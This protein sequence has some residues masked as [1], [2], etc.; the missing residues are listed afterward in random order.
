MKRI[1]KQT[2]ETATVVH[3]STGNLMNKRRVCPTALTCTK[4]IGQAPPREVHFR[5]KVKKM[6]FCGIVTC[7]HIVINSSSVS[8]ARRVYHIFD[9]SP[10]VNKKTVIQT[11]DT[12]TE[13]KKSQ[14]LACG[15]PRISPHY[16]AS[17]PCD[18]LSRKGV[19]FTQYR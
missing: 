6:P 8:S 14:R 11:R 4:G 5:G 7:L 12:S 15:W 16:V 9:A 17:D 10:T 3:S 19:I 1:K 18:M 2:R 13:I